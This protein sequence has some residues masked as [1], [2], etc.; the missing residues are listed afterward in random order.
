M[1]KENLPHFTGLDI[2]TSTVRCVVG[3]VNDDGQPEII[4]F[5]SAPSAGVRKGVVVMPEETALAIKQAVEDAIR[6]GGRDVREVTVNING[7]HVLGSNS[8]GVVA[9]S[10]ANREITGEDRMR[11]EEA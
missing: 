3:V 10:A 4:G 5:G 6:H 1:Q 2:G 11:V 8:R 9:I 7:A